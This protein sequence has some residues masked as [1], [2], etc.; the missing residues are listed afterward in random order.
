[1]KPT[2]AMRIAKS[3][4]G[5]QLT[6]I[7]QGHPLDEIYVHCLGAAIVAANS[8]GYS[9]AKITEDYEAMQRGLGK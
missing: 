5:N 1:M 9:T 2:D 8:L 4:F 3:K 6:K 7:L